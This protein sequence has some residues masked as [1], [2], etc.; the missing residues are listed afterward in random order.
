MPADAPDAPRRRV[1]P[2]AAAGSLWWSAAWTGLAPAVL[3]AVL[4]IAGVA[5]SWLPVS[6]THGSAGSVIRAGGLTFLAALHGG[7][8]VDGVPAAFVPLGLTAILALLAWRAGTGLADVIPDLDRCPPGRLLGAA[9]LQAASF[10][11]TCGLAAHLSTLGTSSVSAVAA[12][13]AGLLLFGVSGSVAF[14]RAAGLLEG[15]P[16]RLRVAGRVGT[17]ALLAYAGAGALLVAASLVVHRDRV[18]VLSHQVGG[19]WSG[20]PVLVLGVLAVPN[21]AI[22][23][24]SY[25]AGPGFAVGHG[26]GVS[27]GAAVHGT[28]PAFPVLGALP[29]SPADTATWLLATATPILAG[30]VLVRGVRSGAAGREP[31]LRL[32]A[33]LAVLTGLGFLAAWLAGGAIGSGRLSAVGASPW[34]FGLAVAGGAAAVAVPSLAGLTALEWWRARQQGDEPALPALLRS[35]PG[36][37]SS[38]PDDGKSEDQLAG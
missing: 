18:Q 32:A 23:A 16:E 7:I 26:S 19:G 2:P 25:L 17:A 8:T 11:V 21:A 9:A 29:S 38:G 24:A 3:G 30:L 1:V 35:V 27:L 22:A 20:A 34:Q 4:G 28:L 31:W 6:G 14:A 15:L 36:L 13:V 10:A 33:A 12:V 5:I 37:R